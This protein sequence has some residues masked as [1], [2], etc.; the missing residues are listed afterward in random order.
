MLVSKVSSLSTEAR[1]LYW[2]RERHS[3]YLRR[4]AGKPK[5]WTDDAILQNYFFTNPYRENDK[6]TV[7]F[8]ET[9]REPLRN[10]PRVLMA[11]VIFQ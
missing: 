7:W 1:F 11:T 9:I 3:I 8:R 2:I 6:T 4:K 10:D 5:P